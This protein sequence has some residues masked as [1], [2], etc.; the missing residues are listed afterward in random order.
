MLQFEEL[1]E[2]IRRN[3]L[4]RESMGNS[5]LLSRRERNILLDEF[6]NNPVLP[7]S[8]EII[9]YVDTTS[10]PFICMYTFNG[11]P[12]NREIT[13]RTISD[14]AQEVNVAYDRTVQMD[15]SYNKANKI[16]RLKYMFNNYN[17]I[18]FD[19]RTW[20]YVLKSR[21]ERLGLLIDDSRIK[22]TIHIIFSKITDML[23]DENKEE[24]FYFMYSSLTNYGYP[25]GKYISHLKEIRD[26]R[27]NHLEYYY[28]LDADAIDVIEEMTYK[29]HKAIDDTEYRL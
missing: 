4:T 14:V 1:P 20:F 16:R 27:S 29:L 28:R 11:D 12:S 21:S 19:P 2:D 3:I 22:R 5:R 18:T 10:F 24:L 23:I 15:N 9:E 26:T 8:E 7:S 13:I 6:I 25:T 17:M